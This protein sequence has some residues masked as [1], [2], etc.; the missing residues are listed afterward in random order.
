MT[1]NIN[2]FFFQNQIKRYLNGYKLSFV[3][4]IIANKVDSLGW[5]W[6]DNI[7]PKFDVYGYIYLLLKL[8]YNYDFLSE[9]RLVYFSKT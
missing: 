4:D 7:N 9:D 6:R 1:L 3:V 5:F 8:G 2:C